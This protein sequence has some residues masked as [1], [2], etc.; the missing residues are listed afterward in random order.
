MKRYDPEI[1]GFLFDR[2]GVLPLKGQGNSVVKC[3]IEVPQNTRHP[4]DPSRDLWADVF[5]EMCL[6]FFNADVGIDDV[7]PPLKAYGEERGELK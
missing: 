6:L 4:F 7:G 2:F 5:D 3:D 1:F